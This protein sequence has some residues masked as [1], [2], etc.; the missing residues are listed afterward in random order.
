MTIQTCVLVN[1]QLHHIEN[2][3]DNSKLCLIQI[4]IASYRK[5]SKTIPNCV[6]AKFPSQLIEDIRKQFQFAT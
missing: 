6:L 3:L 2:I 4:P 5:H 1:F